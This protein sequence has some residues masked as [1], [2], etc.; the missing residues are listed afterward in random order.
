MV[1]RITIYY[2][3][4]PYDMIHNTSEAAYD[5]GNTNFFKNVKICTV[6]LFKH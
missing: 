2:G 3:I 5:T 6:S 1:Y 4:L